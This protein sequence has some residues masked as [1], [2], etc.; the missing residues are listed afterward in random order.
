MTKVILYI[1]TSLD[2]FIARKNGDVDWLFADQD[3]GYSEF[4]K[5][6]GI[7]VM[8]NKTYKQALSF[9]ESYSGKECYVFSRKKKGKNGNAVFVSGDVRK[10]VKKLKD[11]NIWLA[12]GAEIIKE[13]LRYDLI[14]DFMIFVHPILLGEGIPLFKGS[15]AEKKLKLVNIKRYSSGLVSLH[16]KR[17]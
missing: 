5:K 16:Y 1:A 8:G 2:G 6:I 17:K 10:F 11:K 7:V 12:G 14:D 15:F 13:F 3:Y 4:Y 9:G